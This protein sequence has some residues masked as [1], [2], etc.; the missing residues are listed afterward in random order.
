M[1]KRLMLLSQIPARM[2]KPSPRSFIRCN[3][4]WQITGRVS[5]TN[6][7]ACCEPLW[8]AETG[9]V[10]NSSAGL[11]SNFSEIEPVIERVF[12]QII[13]NPGMIFQVNTWAE[14]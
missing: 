5:A 9:K 6:W 1:E 2:M 12:E 11:Y 10:Q 8:V 7:P 14:K 3:R 4:Q 13:L